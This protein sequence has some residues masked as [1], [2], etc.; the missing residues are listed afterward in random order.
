MW[1]Y[2]TFLK[3]DKTDGI[4]IHLL[5]NEFMSQAGLWLVTGWG[6][7]LMLIDIRQMGEDKIFLA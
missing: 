2:W 4:D 1:E 6:N 7:N 3:M 5:R